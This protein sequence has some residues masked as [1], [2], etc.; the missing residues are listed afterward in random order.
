MTGNKPAVASPYLWVAVIKRPRQFVEVI[1]YLPSTLG[2]YPPIVQAL[3][4]WT[5]CPPSSPADWIGPA[6]RAFLF[7]IMSSS[8]LLRWH[9][10]L[11]RRGENSR[12]G[13]QFCSTKQVDQA[14]C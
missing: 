10:C 1:F 5:L 3:T 12:H 11:C 9:W 8:F 7:F 14:L 4:A 6:D 2:L 13:H